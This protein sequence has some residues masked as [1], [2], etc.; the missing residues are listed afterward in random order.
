MKGEYKRD[1]SLG[2]SVA[3]N[4]VFASANIQ[5]NL[6]KPNK[7]VEKTKKKFFG[8]R[9]ATRRGGSLCPPARP[10]GPFICIIWISFEKFPAAGGDEI[11]T[12]C[13]EIVKHAMRG[14][15]TNCIQIFQ[16]L[17]TFF[18]TL[19]VMSSLV[20]AA[21]SGANTKKHCDR[22]KKGAVP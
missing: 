13:V 14:N 22:Q 15:S 9:L 11:G 3:N 16:I 19:R 21:V 1:K 4:Q 5:K 10:N 17:F 12:L 6:T 20:R 18:R 8:A 2:G 7:R